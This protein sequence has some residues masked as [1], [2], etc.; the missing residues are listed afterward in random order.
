M[1]M[2]CAIAMSG[3]TVLTLWIQHETR[4]QGQGGGKG[5]M[6]AAGLLEQGE[7]LVQGPLQYA[8]LS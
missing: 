8:P 3:F 5:G 6:P 2:T 4:R 1:G 7:V